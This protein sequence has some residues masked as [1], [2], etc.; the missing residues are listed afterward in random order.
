MH[1]EYAVNPEEIC[2]SWERFRFFWGQC[3]FARGRLIARFPGKWKRSVF[4]S[5]T[6]NALS[7]IRQKRIE[8]LLAKDG[9]RMVASQR[10]YDK[11]SGTWLGAAISAHQAKPFH[12]IIDEENPGM[13]PKV[14]FFDDVDEATELWKSDTS[15]QVRRTSAALG[16]CTRQLLS[17]G[18]MVKIID[19]Y[20]SFKR[21]F[22][23]PLKEFL[24][25]LLPYVSR[26]ESLE[27]HFKYSQHARNY[28][29]QDFEQRLRSDIINKRR[30]YLPA[31]GD[32]L[33]QKLVFHAWEDSDVETLHAR[34]ILTELGGMQFERGLDSASQSEAVSL[35]SLMSEDDVKDYH[36]RYTPPESPFTL[37]GSFRASELIR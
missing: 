5:D 6:F 23:G 3:G 26:L 30:F 19:P 25:H 27:I 17:S 9:S 4:R 34:C 12:A 7:P 32:A 20:F 8:D 16:Q 1:K 28:D 11:S 37:K 18:R 15:A 10:E 36:A 31:D 33:F 13:H 21:E 29:W 22:T 24:T 14:L 35:V 2:R